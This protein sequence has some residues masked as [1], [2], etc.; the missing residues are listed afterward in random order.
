M[1][2]RRNDGTLDEEGW[3]KV[4]VLRVLEEQMKRVDHGL[5]RSH[6]EHHETGFNA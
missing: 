3:M 5:S 4:F 2:S 6:E 1:G